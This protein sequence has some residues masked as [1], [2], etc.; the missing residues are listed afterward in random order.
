MI[1]VSFRGR[2]PFCDTKH[3]RTEGVLYRSNGCTVLNA[4]LEGDDPVLIKC[5]S[6]GELAMFKYEYLCCA[7]NRCLKC[8]K[9]NAQR[10]AQNYAAAHK[11]IVGTK[12]DGWVTVQAT[13]IRSLLNLRVKSIKA[14]RSYINAKNRK[15][16]G[17]Q[18][19]VADL[20]TPGMVCSVCGERKVEGRWVEHL[21]S[22]ICR[23]CF[24]SFS[25]VRDCDAETPQV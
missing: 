9:L 4:R 19:I 15:V 16:P 21:G 1:K 7:G 14:K 25:G 6:C 23:G 3:K 2:C 8:K 10:A 24:N 18:K 12:T 17:P 20:L 11:S 13:A 22:F 5:P